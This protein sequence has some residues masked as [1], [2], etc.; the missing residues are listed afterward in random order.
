M[1]G[2]FR[3]R[4]GRTRMGAEMIC[5]P[6]GVHWEYALQKRA[7]SCKNPISGTS[8]SVGEAGLEEKQEARVLEG[9]VG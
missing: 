4:L 7:F 2:D 3:Y 8:V 9:K 1:A 5:L 6:L